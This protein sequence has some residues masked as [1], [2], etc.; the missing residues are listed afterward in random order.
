MM[1]S[2][3]YPE[4]GWEVD[5]VWFWL[6]NPYSRLQ[7]IDAKDV[8]EYY[9]YV[10]TTWVDIEAQYMIFEGCVL[11]HQTFDMQ[12]ELVFGARSGF[13]SFMIANW[14]KMRDIWIR[15]RS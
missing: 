11:A 12:K 8:H 9:R 2:E 3:L 5:Q 14:S 7:L 10:H 15:N 1:P 4:G 13:R 6:K